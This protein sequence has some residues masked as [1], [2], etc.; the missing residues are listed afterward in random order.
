MSFLVQTVCPGRAWAGA[1]AA[2]RFDGT[3]VGIV[4]ATSTRIQLWNVAEGLDAEP[5]CEQEAFGAVRSL[6][7]LPGGSGGADALVLLT[8]LGCLSLLRLDVQL[9]RCEP[10]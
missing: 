2:G 8:D 7:C 4:T 1:C 10:G 6:A 3:A 5:L 9:Q